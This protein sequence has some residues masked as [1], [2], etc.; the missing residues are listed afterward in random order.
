[1][2]G[3]ITHV[4]ARAAHTDGICPLLTAAVSRN[5]LGS[6]QSCGGTKGLPRLGA[7]VWKG[8][9]CEQ[10][11]RISPCGWAADDLMIKVCYGLPVSCY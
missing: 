2:L 9:T 11:R 4:R 5:V 10:E 1:M 3:A 6:Y 7:S 8:H